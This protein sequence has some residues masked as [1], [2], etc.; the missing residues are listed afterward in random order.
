MVPCN[1]NKNHN[2]LRQ[3][4]A[5]MEL[6][7]NT[8]AM[9]VTNNLNLPGPIYKALSIDGYSHPTEPSDISTTSL[10]GPPRIFQL[11]KRHWN[12]LEEDAADRVWQLFGQA[13][14]IAAASGADDD[15]IA[16]KRFYMPINGWVLSGQPDLYQFHEQKMI[17]LPSG[18]PSFVK[19][20]GGAEGVEYDWKSTKIYALTKEQS[21]WQ[22]QVNVNAMLLRYNKHK[23][24]A[25]NIVAFLKDWNK[26]KM[27]VSRNYPQSPL[28]IVPIQM[29]KESQVEAYAKQRIVIHQQAADL[30]DDELP[31]CTDEEKWMT[32]TSYAVMAD[33]GKVASD[34]YFYGDVEDPQRAAAD[35][36]R[37]LTEASRSKK[38][39]VAKKNYQVQHRPGMPKKCLDYCPVRGI[40]KTGIQ[41]KKDFPEPVLDI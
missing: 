20:E 31:P 27:K 2:N 19:V 38:T 7:K 40:C 41:A 8:Y 30:P 28:E 16:E 39:G 34:V 1:R 4:E 3:N 21:D 5:W 25:G 29:W 26:A 15:S 23:V 14:H 36:A 9:K 33:G 24:E 32:S 17:W 10:I 35:R 18:L 12:E 6:R 37:E 13:L 22:A 11:R